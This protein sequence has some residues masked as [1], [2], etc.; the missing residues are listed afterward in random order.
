[1]RQRARKDDNQTDIVA[2]LRQIGATVWLTHQLGDG[3]PDIVVGFRGVNYMLELKDGSKPPSEQLLTAEEARFGYLW[4]GQYAVV[5]S[6]A[7]AV[8]VI[9]AVEKV[10]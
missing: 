10:G 2:G 9:G 7:E 8:L 3:A 6:F 4:K 5:H 1:M